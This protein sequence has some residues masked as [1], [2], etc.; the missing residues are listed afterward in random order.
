MPHGWNK[1][2]RC[3]TKWHTFYVTYVWFVEGQNS[4]KYLKPF[5]TS[6]FSICSR[7]PENCT[8]AL[9]QNM[10]WFCGE[11]EHIAH[12]MLFTTGKQQQHDTHTQK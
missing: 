3:I 12:K 4:F 11:R 2:V 10:R 9:G 8:P 7:I 5:G 6:G 1:S